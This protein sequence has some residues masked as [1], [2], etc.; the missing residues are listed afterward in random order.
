MIAKKDLIIVTLVGFI[1]VV[2]FYPRTTA[3]QSSIASPSEYDPWI[4]YNDDGTINYL[5]LYS[6]AKAYGTLGVPTKKVEVTNW[7]VSTEVN[8]WWAEHVGPSDLKY[9]STFNAS[10]FGHLHILGNVGLDLVGEL[11]LMISARIWN[12]NHTAWREVRV[13]SVAL[14]SVYPYVNITIPV[15]GEEFFF[16][17]YCDSISEGYVY[18]SFYL[19]WA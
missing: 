19:T 18:L 14:T 5:D 13:Y 12:A 7:P 16:V 15:P 4:D 11:G 8:V 10:G 2:T 17:T 6:L 1:L 3:S 9:S